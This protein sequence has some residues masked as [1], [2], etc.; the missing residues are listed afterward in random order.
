MERIKQA[1][2]SEYESYHYD[3]DEM[4]ETNKQLIKWLEESNKSLQSEWNLEG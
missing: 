4:V 2:I 3:A 1:I